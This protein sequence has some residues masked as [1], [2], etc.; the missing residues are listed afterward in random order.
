[1]VQQ[2]DNKSLHI[3][4]TIERVMIFGTAMRLI[5]EFD[6]KVFRLV[7][8]DF[9]GASQTQAA[10]ML[11]CS[12]SRVNQALKRVRAVM[13]S[14]FPIISVKANLIRLCATELGMGAVSIA[15]LLGLN[16]RKVQHYMT[17][18]REK[19]LLPCCGKTKLSKATLYQEYMAKDIKQKF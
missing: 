7:H 18:L 3:L 8:Q 17:V 13:P 9:L 11:G 6:E 15:D 2:K 4:P 14:F 10:S 19:H 12:T 1:M 16:L 5:S